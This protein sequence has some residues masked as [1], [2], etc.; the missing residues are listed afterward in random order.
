MINNFAESQGPTD[1]GIHR[2]VVKAALH[3]PESAAG[4]FI[5]DVVS[6][7][8]MTA[9]DGVV[10]SRLV[11]DPAVVRPVGDAAVVGPVGDAVVVRPV[12]AVGGT[13]LA[14]LLA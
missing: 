13:V 3:I 4:V 14:S 1:H 9:I 7:F 2:S 8:D 5:W 12:A 11:G 10:S 6:G